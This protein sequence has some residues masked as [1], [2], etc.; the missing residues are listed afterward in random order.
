MHRVRIYYLSLFLSPS[1]CFP[2]GE[3]NKVPSPP[4]S[5][6]RWSE[7]RK[8][9]WHL[10]A[11]SLTESARC[12]LNGFKLLSGLDSPSC[13]FHTFSHPPGSDGSFSG[14][15]SNEGEDEDYVHYVGSRCWLIRLLRQRSVLNCVI[16]FPG[17]INMVRH[18]VLMARFCTF[19]QL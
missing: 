5:S 3:S 19:N 17:P 8:K 16:P 14:Q 11:S 12:L 4:N 15:K 13:L 1:F 18:K 7:E 6:E 9:R 10:K 2:A